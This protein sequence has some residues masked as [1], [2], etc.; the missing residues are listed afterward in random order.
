LTEIFTVQ[1][2]S[3]KLHF[4]DNHE[5]MV[6]FWGYILLIL[7]KVRLSSLISKRWVWSFLL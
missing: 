4:T 1:S 6:G 3:L 2:Y 5:D 7:V